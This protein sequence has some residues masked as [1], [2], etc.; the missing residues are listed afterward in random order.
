MQR[1]GFWERGGSWVIAQNTLMVLIMIVSPLSSA[2]GWAP[3]W[4]WI[5]GLFVAIS[6]VY[7]VAG[8]IALGKN[9]T[10]FPSPKADAELVE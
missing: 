6:A 9:R 4:R 8:V 1:A 3:V 2:M 10:V 7:G 5:G